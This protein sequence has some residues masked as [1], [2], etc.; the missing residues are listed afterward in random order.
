MMGQLPR[1]M[2]I[3]FFIGGCSQPASPRGE[4]VQWGASEVARVGDVSV[5]RELLEQVTNSQQSEPSDALERVIR[6][7]LVGKSLEQGARER[8][9]YLSR[10]VLA[11]RMEE[12]WRQEARAAG[13][14]TDE[15]LA[16]FTQRHWSELDRPRMART[17]HAVVTVQEGQSRAA[18]REVAQA[19]RAAVLGA[20]SASE[21]Q[22]R[23]RAFASDEYDIRVEALQPVALDGRVLPGPSG[24][25]EQRYDA[26]FA[27]AAHAL[28][29]VGEVSDVSETRFG[30]HVIFLAEV[31]PAQRVALEDRRSRL[32]EEIFA[33]RARRLEQ[34]ALEE[35]RRRAAVEVGPEALT[36]ME[37]VAVSP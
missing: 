23:A 12:A 35:M 18:A 25:R 21:F 27:R 26:E 1:W 16:T 8:A 4:Q 5:T 33:E 37:R 2:A 17:V 24:S 7:L 19:L 14:P 9:V 15:E 36:L 32:R 10:T 31:L 3:V 22:E 11:R 6:T 29:T 13:E 28:S 20:S 34:A 30:F